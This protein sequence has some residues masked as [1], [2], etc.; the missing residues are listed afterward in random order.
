MELEFDDKIVV[1]RLVIVREECRALPDVCSIPK[2]SQ[3]H[4]VASVH[5]AIARQPDSAEGAHHVL[6]LHQQFAAHR[7][8]P[9]QQQFLQVREQTH[10]VRVLYNIIMYGQMSIDYDAPASSS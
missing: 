2:H 9:W 1:G 3:Q 4:V 10:R 5:D 6:A 7:A 8:E